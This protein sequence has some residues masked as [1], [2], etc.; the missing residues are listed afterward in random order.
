MI[1]PVLSR[2][3]LPMPRSEQHSGVPVPNRSCH[4]A[5]ALTRSAG[6]PDGTALTSV[7]VKD[8][9]EPLPAGAAV[10]PPIRQRE[11]A[12]P[13]QPQSATAA[14]G[15][16]PAPPLRGSSP[17]VALLLFDSLWPT[18]FIVGAHAPSPAGI[19]AAANKAPQAPPVVSMHW[20]RGHCIRYATKACRHRSAR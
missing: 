17:G 11:L 20:M 14:L 3:S 10:A 12:P 8:R 15:R 7:D 4:L 2:G 5:L 13:V 1:V 19:G 16:P 18:S 9:D 6:A